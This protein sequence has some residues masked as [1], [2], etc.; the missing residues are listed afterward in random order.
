[1]STYCFLNFL[2]QTKIFPQK[3]TRL[4]LIYSDICELNYEPKKGF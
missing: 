1:M 3:K 4:T 2:N